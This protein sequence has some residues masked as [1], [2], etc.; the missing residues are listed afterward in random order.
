M[1][2]SRIEKREG[3]KGERGEKRNSERKKEK[4]RERGGRIIAFPA[5]IRL[6][7]RFQLT[8]TSRLYSREYLFSLFNHL[9]G[10]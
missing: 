2:P 7:R 5:F 1:N 6:E 3:K 9:V 10:K 8:V 4:E